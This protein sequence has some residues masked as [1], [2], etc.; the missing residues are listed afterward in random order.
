MDSLP[1]KQR[2][3]FSAIYGQPGQYV[4]EL[5][6]EVGLERTSV[7]RIV[8]ILERKGLIVSHIEH[9]PARQGC[10]AHRCRILQPAPW[11]LH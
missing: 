8:L 4:R 10:F 9:V 11:T 5:A 2:L 6:R 7:D 3:V 1:D